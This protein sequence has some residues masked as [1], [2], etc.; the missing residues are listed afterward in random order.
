MTSEPAR[1]ALYNRVL[2]SEHA[3]TLMTSL[4]MQPATEPATKSD[5]ELLRHEFGEL[6]SEFQEFHKALRDQQRTYTVLTIS[7]L[8]AQTAIFSLIV[9]IVV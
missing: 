2:G 7:A 9:G 8:T 5:I 3:E 4:P 1:L 6:R